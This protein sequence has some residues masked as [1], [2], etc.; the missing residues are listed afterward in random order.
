MHAQ[1]QHG[2]V[3]KRFVATIMPGTLA[4]MPAPRVSVRLHTSETP[5]RVGGSDLE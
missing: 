1:V 4:P 3:R 2:N 5:A